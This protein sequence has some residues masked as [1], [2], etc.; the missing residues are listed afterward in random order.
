MHY[1]RQATDLLLEN[2]KYDRVFKLYE[3]SFKNENKEC[4]C[5]KIERKKREFQLRDNYT[6]LDATIILKMKKTGIF[7]LNFLKGIILS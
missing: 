1:Y 4:F 2:W 7:V 6:K 5:G 3:N